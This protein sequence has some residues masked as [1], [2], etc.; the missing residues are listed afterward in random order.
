MAKSKVLVHIPFE[1]HK[2]EGFAHVQAEFGFSTVSSGRSVAEYTY[3]VEHA[4]CEPLTNFTEGYPKHKNHLTPPFILM[5]NQ[6]G[7][8]AV[9][10]ARHA[11]QVGAAALLIAH[12]KCLCSDT[13]CVDKFKQQNDTA[14]CLTEEPALVDDGSGSDISIP[15]FLVYKDL[16]SELHNQMKQK[17]QPCLLEFQWGIQDGNMEGRLPRFHLWTTAYDPLVS[18]EF[19]VGIKTVAQGFKD[20]VEFAPRFSLIDGKRFKCDEQ[21]DENAPC[22]HLVSSN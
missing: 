5:A 16:T 6:G 2:P 10:K 13:D 17:D 7:C 15:T 21:P 4:L 1:I 19:Y 8:S 14:D 18:L 22:D 12:G 3:Y 11:Q 9:T 20:K